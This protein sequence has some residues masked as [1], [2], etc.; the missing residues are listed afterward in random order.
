MANLRLLS[1]SVP[2]STTIAATFSEPL[3]ENIAVSNV[4]LSSQTPGVA[5][6]S[7]LSVSIVGPTLT[8][9]TQP[10][11]PLAAYFVTFISTSTQPFNSLNGDAVI[12]NDG[13]TNRQLITGPQDPSNPIQQYL[14]N[15]LINNLYNLE[16]PSVVYSHIQG[17]ATV[18]STALY[19]IRQSGNENYLSFSVTDEIQTRGTG[20]FDRLNEESAYEVTR[21]GTTPTGTNLS[22]ITQVTSFPSYPISV[23]ATNNAENVTVSSNDENG[24][25]NINTFT[26]NLSKRFVI[27]LNSVIFIYSSSSYEYDIQK[28]GYQILDSK[29]DPDHAFSYG[30]LA[31][32]QIIL[33]SK[34]LSD[35]LFSTNDIVSIQVNYQFKNTGKIIDSSSLVVDTILPSGRE[36]VPPIENIFTLKHAPI[37]TAGDKIGSV[38]DITFIDPNALP[39]SNTPHPAFLYEVPFRLNYLPSVPGEYSVDYSTGNVY[40]YGSSTSKDGTGG[41]PPLA[42]YNYRYT[43]VPQI[44]YVY[45]SD[46]L[47]IVALPFGNLINSQA[48]IIYNY[49][50]VLAEGI[51]YTA[52]VHIESLNENIK[53]RL[54]AINAIQPLNFPVTDVFRIYNQ[55]S[56]EIYN[57]LRF[58]NNTIYFN[59]VNPPNIVSETGER[60]SFQD[61]LNEILSVGAVIPSGSNNIYQIFLTNNNII[62]STQDCIGSS[63]NTSVYFSNTSIFKQEKYF[64]FSLS[65]DV[66]NTRLINIGDYQIDYKNGIIWCL[67]PSSQSFSVGSVSYKR[68]YIAPQNPHLI[69]VDNIY[70]RFNITSPILKTFTYTNFSDGSILPSSFDF[71][72]EKFFMGNSGEPYVISGGQVGEFINATFTPGVTSPVKYVRGLFEYDDLLNN[73]EPINFAQASVANGMSISVSPLNFSEYHSVQ[74][75]GTHY[76]ILANTNLL[77]QSPNITMNFTIKRLSDQASLPGSVVLG[78]P[79]KIVLSGVNS[80]HTGDAVVL[81]YSYT[82]NNLSRIVVDYNRG[83]YFIDYT[84]LADEILISYE[85]GDNVLDFSQSNALSQGQQYY[86][87]YKVGALRDALLANF[88]TLINLPILNTLDVSF[89]R[90]RYR[91]ALMAAMQ[92]FTAGPTVTSMSN[93]VQHIVHTKPQIIESAFS[94]W[95]LGS[96]LLNPQPIK[97]T[98]SFILAPAKYDNGVVMDTQGQTIKFPVSSNLRLEQGSLST[99]VIPE[100]N[101]IDNQ[102]DITITIFKNGVPLPPQNIFIG[103]AAYHP[104]IVGNVPITINTRNRVFGKPNESKDGVFIYYEKDQSGLFNRWY[105]DVLDG[106]ADG[107]SVKNYKILISTNGKFYDVKST[108]TSQPTTDK[109]FSGTNTL[110]YTI[111]GTSQVATG[112]TFIADSPHYIFDFGNAE[113]QNRFSLYKDESGYLNFRVTDK[114]K[115]VYSVSSDVSSWRAGEKH[116][117]ACSWSL[118]TK[119]ARD[120]LHLFIDGFEVPNIIVYKS[121][122]VPYLH[123]KFR[124]INPEEVVGKIPKAIVSSTDLVT[125]LNSNVVTSSIDFTAYGVQSGATIFIN[126][127]GFSTSGYTVSL[128]NGQSLT[129]TTPMPL[130]GNGLSYSVNPTAFDVQT[131]INLYSNIVVS[132]L[133]QMNVSF[134]PDLHT[135]NGSNVVTSTNT[136]FTNLGVLPGYV[137]AINESGF[138]PTYTILSVSGNSLTLNDNTFPSFTNAAYII[139]PNVEQEIPGQRALF[140]AYGISTDQYDNV[141]LTVTNDAKPNDIVLI[142]TLGLNLKY[143]DKEY[144][145]WNGTSNPNPVNTIMTRLPPPVLLA[146]VKIT[147]ILLDGYDVGP[148]NS[149]VVGGAFVSTIITDQPSLSDH[150]RTLLVSMAGTNVNYNTAATVVITGTINNVPSQTETLTFTQNGQQQT[151]SKFEHVNNIIVTCTPININSSCVVVSVQELYPITFPENS[152]TVPT[153]RYSYQMFAGNTLSGSGNT[154]TDPNGFF[155]VETIGNYLVITSPSIAAGQYQIVGVSAD[156]KSATLSLPVPTFSGGIYQILNVSTYR[157]GLQNGFFTFEQADG[158][159][160]VPYNLVQGKYRFEYYSYLSIPMGV[161]KLYGFVGSDLNGKNLFNGTLDEFQIV[162]EKL[163]DTRIGETASI[164]QETITKDFNSL[165]ALEPTAATLMLLHFDT[166][167]FKNAA[168]VY[169]TSTNQFIQS[170]VAVNNNFGKSVCI[171]DKPILID[172]TGILNSKEQG[173]IEFWVSPLY[174]TGNDPNY[175]FYFDATAMVSEQIVSENNATVKIAGRASKILSVKLQVGSQSVDYFAGGVIDSDNQ[176]LFLN[177]QLPNQQ[178]PVVVNYIPTGT[179]GDRI[180]IYKDPAGY[181][182]FDVR[183][184]GVDYQVRSPAFWV[185]DT[186]HRL[187][188]QYIFNA[189]LGSDQIKFFIDGYERGNILFGNGLLFGQGQVFGSSFAGQ[190][191]IQASISFKDTINTIF[192][193]SDF[194]GNNGAYALIDNLRISDISRPLFMPFGE[195]IDVNYSSNLSIVYPVTQDLYTTLLLDFNSLLTLQTDF[196]TLKNKMIG[197]FDFS[198]NI[199][200]SFGIVSGSNTVKQVLETLINTLKPA[201]SRVYINYIE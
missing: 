188:A 85:Y 96:S 58:T 3:N 54:I 26:L 53:N 27:I 8:I 134:T 29:F 49:E 150:G 112:I 94:N 76:Y 43:F 157:S 78:T 170:A 10:L 40:V 52:D 102:S 82:I 34:I 132:L 63:I 64:D 144:Y 59:Y 175:R 182:N 98:G 183:A 127:P 153:I 194:T 116:Q 128:V 177:R 165:V 37:V 19:S 30:T 91:D 7:I 149:T 31:D 83:D 123:E 126:E 125:V 72:D 46:S 14:T 166:F 18:L 164:N 90:E 69:T 119:N 187:R 33:N 179:N 146:D 11:V 62:S 36:I 32:N 108:S 121:K 186:W 173:T 66:N 140:P 87:S 181:I 199:F 133:H 159:V 75:D 44:D 81:T 106:Y 50:N 136:N 39:G 201:N 172:N 70:Y 141:S 21:V 176:T 110:T 17:L 38:G 185:K 35:P 155:S 161:D 99:W 158:Y 80:P 86:V 109:I 56:G 114:E 97:T 137:I 101:G 89:E 130:S 148:N 22:N 84:Y 156:H 189:G 12:L 57:T 191:T 143:V 105:M 4:L 193:G 100:W 79:F 154:V 124:T 74:F 2:S 190:S 142:R 93:L 73:V 65:Q 171:T 24:T 196:A 195:S 167:P 1:V 180:S 162:S 118:N 115:N 71:S 23:Q 163:T 42:S 55:T 178:T 152:L 138:A 120:E 197:L 67:V 68:G 129:L 28:Y 47:E 192:I 169:T 6:P 198:I 77:Y 103:P 117:V 13:V 113:N 160:G 15:F 92:S 135:T 147:H 139:Y 41:F 107:Y 9:T 60:A 145:L 20:P 61:V 111:T 200:D 45:D 122:V 5:D 184:S 95:S 16:P 168:S 48:N 51:D 174:D 131:E 151:L 25:F 88:G 104:V